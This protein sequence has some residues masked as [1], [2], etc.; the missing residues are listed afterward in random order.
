MIPFYGSTNSKSWTG[1]LKPNTSFTVQKLDELEARNY[2][3][4]EM[5]KSIVYDIDQ[6]MLLRSCPGVNLLSWASMGY[7][8]KKQFYLLF[9][10]SARIPEISL[11]SFYVEQPGIKFCL[12]AKLNEKFYAATGDGVS[13]NKAKEECAEN[14]IKKMDLWKYLMLNHAETTCD[15]YLK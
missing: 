1:G 7:W 15:Q 4:D 11:I 13:K 14:L 3:P 10:L 8:K 12:V 5:F 9:A 6:N 2:L